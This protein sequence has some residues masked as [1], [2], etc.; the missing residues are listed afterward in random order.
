M[1]HRKAVLALGVIAALTPVAA[2]Q[3]PG[4]VVTVTRSAPYSCPDPPER[5]SVPVCCRVVLEIDKDGKTAAAGAKCSHPAYEAVTASC[6][7]GRPQEQ[8]IRT[9]GPVAY[10][11]DFLVRHF[12]KMPSTQEIEALDAL[13]GQVEKPATKPWPVS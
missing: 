9:G 11:R 2:S 3:P 10:T 4:A 7:A 13:C 12:P 6:Q 1:I 5:S 8:Q